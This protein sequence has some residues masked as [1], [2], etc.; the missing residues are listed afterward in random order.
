LDSVLSVPTWYLA[1]IGVVWGSL[2]LAA[3]VGL[4]IGRAWALPVTRWGGIAYV[5]WFWADRILLAR[6]GYAARTRPFDLIVSLVL[7]AC[8]WWVLQRPASRSYF[9]ERSS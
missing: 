2:G 5:L 7:L 9:R 3:A 6:S 1:L 4:F 8:V